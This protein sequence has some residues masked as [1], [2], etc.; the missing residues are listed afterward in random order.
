MVREDRIIDRQWKH[1]N[2]A[3]MVFRPKQMT[4]DRLL[5]GYLD[6]WRGFY[7]SKS[8]LASLEHSDRTIQF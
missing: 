2:D 5:Q 4:P 1:Y 8:F 7:K 3:N 6:L